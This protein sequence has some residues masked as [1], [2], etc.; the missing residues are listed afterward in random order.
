MK[1]LRMHRVYS[2][3]P[4]RIIEGDSA[5]IPD[6]L[7]VGL[8]KLPTPLRE[9]NALFDTLR[10]RRKLKPLIEGTSPLLPLRMQQRRPSMGM[11]APQPHNASALDVTQERSSEEYSD[12]SDDNDIPDSSDSDV[13]ASESEESESLEDDLD[14]DD[15]AVWRPGSE[16]S[17]ARDKAVFSLEDFE[18]VALDM[19]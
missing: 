15:D 19:Y 12:E 7:V 10:S 14:E 17:S 4:G 18:D 5:V 3:E 9:Y 11:V 1:S 8:H 2:K 13:S 16:S 6:V